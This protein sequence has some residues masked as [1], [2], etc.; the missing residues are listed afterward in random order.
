MALVN[1]KATFHCELEKVWNV[2]TLFVSL[3][4]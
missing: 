1:I 3:I 4:N 2:V